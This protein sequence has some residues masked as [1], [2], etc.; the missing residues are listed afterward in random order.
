MLTLLIR[1]AFK[2]LKFRSL[3]YIQIFSILFFCYSA[4]L[5]LSLLR[6]SSEFY[7]K[8]KSQELLG[9]DLS[10]TQ[11]TN[12]SE[13]QL[14]LIQNGLGSEIK[15]ST[16]EIQALGML[17]AKLKSQLV[18]IHAV[19]ISF[20]LF[21]NIMGSNKTSIQ[22]LCNTENKK[23]NLIVHKDLLKILNLKW[24]D[25]VKIGSTEFV[26]LD[27]I[28]EDVLSFGFAN[29]GFTPR[30]YICIKDFFKTGLDSIGN[31]VSYKWNFEIHNFKKLEYTQAFLKMSPEFKGVSIRNARDAFETSFRFLKFSLQYLSI[32][33]WSL[34]LISFAVLFLL[35]RSRQKEQGRQE[36]IFN[37]LVNKDD[38]KKNILSFYKFLYQYPSQ[39]VSGIQV[40]FLNILSFLFAILF[41]YLAIKILKNESSFNFDLKFNLLS[42]LIFF[43]IQSMQSLFLI[44]EKNLKTYVFYFLLA[45]L[46]F[47]ASGM[48]FGFEM[49]FLAAV[50]LVLLLA[51]LL[52]FW[53]RFVYFVVQK[54]IPSQISYKK[55]FI[56]LF[57][58]KLELQ[59]ARVLMLSLGVVLGVLVLLVQS[60]PQLYHSLKIELTPM[61]KD[62]ETSV[63]LFNIPQTRIEDLKSWSAK[64]KI[65][66]E[67]VSPLILSRLNEINHQKQSDEYFKKFP[68]RMTER[69]ELTE[70]EKI[71]EGKWSTGECPDLAPV[72]IEES[73]AKRW[74]IKLEDQLNFEIYGE[75]LDAK[76]TSIRRV[77]WNDFKPN[78]FIEFQQGCLK[79]MPRSFLATLSYPS[80]N[81]GILTELT[82]NFQ[83]ISFFNV[84]EALLRVSQ[85]SQQVFQVFFLA[86]WLSGFVSFLLLMYL[87][88][89]VLNLRLGEFS[90]KA[91]LLNNPIIIIAY[92]FCELFLLL[93]TAAMGGS[94][95]VYIFVRF[96][97]EKFLNM[98]S[99]FSLGL[100]SEQFFLLLI[101]GFLFLMICSQNIFSKRKVEHEF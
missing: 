68:L 96:V 60:V 54:V 46:I 61:M 42:I 38:F 3:K 76:V 92:I 83:D 14:K 7:L 11:D 17:H 94:I 80:T 34:Y 97:S 35:L 70:S 82:Q 24:G 48:I 9:G 23:P 22:E 37:I 44:F 78:F 53:I 100:L 75:S 20:P 66:L 21:G 40:L 41:S 10:L 79:G 1:L 86:S 2:E 12:W 43:I 36:F 84:S 88:Y 62:S 93:L 47:N 58:L 51:A 50:P 18:D 71:I 30:V 65:K 67:Y 26:V 74:K 77:H 13:K 56:S 69:A 15:R 52:Y 27:S 95:L 31:Q 85:W 87:I 55:H 59:K 81:S 89:F 33:N 5:F 49:E 29:N 72:S 63:F 28:E 8:E 57:P 101:F 16:H 73:F 6:E 64:N 91:I 39:F 99:H 25:E 98:Q 45:A 90:L 19:D 32:L 4:V